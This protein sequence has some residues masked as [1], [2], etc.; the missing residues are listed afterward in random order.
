MK[1]ALPI[2]HS[3]TRPAR[4]ATY[5]ILAAPLLL[6]P[7]CATIV[8]GTRQKI[9]IVTD[10]PGA[11]A[12]VGPQKVTTPGV[13]RL[14]RRAKEIGILVEK[15]GYTTCRVSLKHRQGALTFLNLLGIPAGAAAGTAI[16][17]ASATG[18]AVLGAGA[19]GFTA[20]AV[21]LPAAAFA[22]DYG[23]GAAYRLEPGK[24]EIALE[25]TEPEASD[26]GDAKGT[27]NSL[28]PPPPCVLETPKAFPQ[29]EKPQPTNTADAAGLG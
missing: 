26:P 12:S 6:A 21:L 9:D 17:G 19:V 11:T 2:P 25:A 28:Q 4:R 27:P 23:T 15:P 14:P 24:V 16:G 3:S 18:L 20:G 8:S 1:Q 7:G 13:L 10:P 5:L 22:V 29:P